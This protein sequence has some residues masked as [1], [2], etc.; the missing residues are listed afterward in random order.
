MYYYPMAS[1][2]SGRHDGVERLGQLID[3]IAEGVAVQYRAG[4]QVITGLCLAPL[5]YAIALSGARSAAEL[6]ARAFSVPAS[7]CAKLI[8]L[9]LGAGGLAA[10]TG[11]QVHELLSYRP[12][13]PDVKASPSHA[14]ALADPSTVRGRS[15]RGGSR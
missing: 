11:W 5:H 12:S 7:D 6:V 15:E 9:S 10:R 13:E 2:A 3:L 1:T 14:G 8:E 4:A